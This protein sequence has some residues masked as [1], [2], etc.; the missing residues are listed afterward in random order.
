MRMKQVFTVAAVIT[1]VTMPA[2][3]AGQKAPSLAFVQQATGSGMSSGLMDTASIFKPSLEV[4][5]AAKPAI[6]AADL[7]GNL[8]L[9]YQSGDFNTASIEQTGTRN[10]GLIQQIGY[11]NSASINQSGIGHQALISQ[12]GRNNVAIIRQR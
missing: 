5:A 9:I 6:G 7:S 2:A 12:Q 1:A 8:S 11:M 10:V 4:I 3:L